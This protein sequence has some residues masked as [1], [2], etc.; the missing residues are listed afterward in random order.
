M[1]NG[2]DKIGDLANLE[3]FDSKAFEADGTVSQDV[4]NFVLTLA[5]IFNDL[6]DL[7]Y[8]HVTLQ[9]HKPSGS[10]KISRPWGAYGGIDL[11]LLRL[12]VGLFHEIIDLIKRSDKVLADPFFQSVLT[13]LRRKE[14][15]IWHTLV[16]VAQ[17]QQTTT[18]ENR[19]ALFVR[20]KLV[21]HYDPK[22]IYW[23]YHNFFCSG[24]HGA[25][26]AFVSRGN[27]MARTRHFFADTAARGYFMKNVQGKEAEVLILKAVE[28]LC[29]M[30]FTL[31]DI[32]HHFIQK[33]GF[34]YKAEVE[35]T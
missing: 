19:F 23:G 18:P 6:K 31:T 34:A 22:E 30:N 13:R 26:R 27:D 10:F 25:E 9:N 14:R 29:D 7:V 8:A 1:N 21:F 4:C 20:N 28:N 11:H 3:S 16:N 15:D 33:R 24:T 5:L 35:E 2:V 17:G 12:M 32:V